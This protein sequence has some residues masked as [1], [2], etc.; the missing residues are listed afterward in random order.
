MINVS[1]EC[2]IAQKVEKEEA[3]KNAQAKVKFNNVE[4]DIKHY[5]NTR[6][7]KNED[8]KELVIRLLPFSEKEPSPFKKIHVHSVKVTNANGEKQWKKYICPVKNNKGDKCPFCETSEKAE[9]MRAEASDEITAKKYGDIAFLNSAKDYWIVRCIDRAHEEDGVKFWRF[10]DARN[11]DGIWD[12]IYALFDTKQRRGVNIFDLYQGKD[13]VITV[14]KKVNKGKET[15]VYQIQDDEQIKPLAP[16]EEQMEA[17]VNDPMSWEDVYSVKPYDYLALIV[18]G[19]VPV[20]D[21]ENNKWVSQ[22]ESNAVQAEAEQK[23]IEENLKPETRDYSDFTVDLKKPA[24]PTVA[25]TV[26][27]E[28]PTEE[29]DD[30]PF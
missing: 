26:T 1:T 27:I 22:T 28:T 12:K 5:L 24:T 16:T 21:K 30:L 29:I 14:N 2:V 4:F 8:T 3:A 10:P 7:E 17:W 15:M 19:E 9:K 23:Q 11:G 6:L 18:Q 25:P 20:W 13:L